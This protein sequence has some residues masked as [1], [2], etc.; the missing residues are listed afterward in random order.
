GWEESD[1]RVRQYMASVTR[2]YPGKHASGRG[3]RVPTPDEQTLCA[4]WREREL[5]LLDL[6][7][8]IPVGKLAIGLY[9]DARLPLNKIIGQVKLE[10]GISIVPLPHPSGAS[11]WYMQPENQVLIEMAIAHL[12]RLREEY[13]L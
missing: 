10:N 12:R 2:C 9:F 13:S 8:I 7:V 11:T 5:Q 1:F 4:K 6:K 3:D